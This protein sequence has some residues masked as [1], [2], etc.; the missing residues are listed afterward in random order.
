ME[1]ILILREK[2]EFMPEL[3]RTVT[4]VKSKQYF[5]KDTSKGFHTTFGVIQP[6]ELQ[7]PD[8]S[9]IKSDQ[10]KEFILFSPQFIDKYKRLRKLP[11]TIPL[12]DIGFII[13]ETGINK[14]SVVLDAGAGSGALAAS[15]A[16]IA[17]KV[18]TYEI[19]PDFVANIK[20]NFASLGLENIELKEKN[21]YEGFD[22]QTADLVTLD[23]PEPWKAVEHAAKAVKVGGFIINY[24]PSVPQVMDF[25][26]AVRKNQ[27]LLLVKTVEQIER[28][29]EFEDRRVRPKSI[30]IGHSGFLTVVRRIT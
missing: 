13:A 10:G 21:V 4:T 5:V 22:E 30:S 6:A 15:L 11:Q 3:D 29:W 8:G 1:R 23:L 28:L 25:V 7:K 17:K 27:H 12:K 16:R 20:E 24:S 9:V 2:K 19:R 18:A 26:A 14:D